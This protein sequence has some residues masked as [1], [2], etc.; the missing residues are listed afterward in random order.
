MANNCVAG[1]VYVKV[2]S[3]QLSVRGSCAITPNRF[4]RTGVSGLDGVHGYSSVFHI[5]Q[6]VVEITN[7][8]QFPLTEI[9]EIVDATVTAELENGEVWV[10][11]NAWVADDTEL[12]AEDGTA[13]VTFQGMAIRRQMAA[14]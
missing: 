1:T 13:S 7:R 4:T 9:T 12:A 8:T 3:R 6:I 10:L 2:D 14:A 5:P 11:R